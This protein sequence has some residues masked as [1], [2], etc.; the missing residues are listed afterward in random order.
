[1]QQLRRAVEGVAAAMVLPQELQSV[2]LLK[3]VD[4]LAA[5]VVSSWR[6]DK[7]KGFGETASSHDALRSDNKDYSVAIEAA[8]ELA[9]AGTYSD[10]FEKTDPL[11]RLFFVCEVLLPPE[12]ILM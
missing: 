1:M 11:K 10:I 8:K 7:D 3:S 12:N 9:I 4:P 6:W 2:H 5:A